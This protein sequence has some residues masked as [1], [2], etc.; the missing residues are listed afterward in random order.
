MSAEL[1]FRIGAT[2]VLI[3]ASAFF[4]ASETTFFNLLG[5]GALG[6]LDEDNPALARKLR[7]LLGAPRRLIASMLIGNEIVNIFISILIATIFARLFL[8]DEPLGEHRTLLVGL[9]SMLAST[10]LLLVFGEVI[11][12][13]IGLAF[14]R[15]LAVYMTVPFY[16]FHKIIFPIRYLFHRASQAVLRL[17]GLRIGPAQEEL[18]E[19]ELKELVELGEEEGLLDETEY[20]LLRNIFEFGDLT[21]SQ[22]MTP[23]QEV[24][25]LPVEIG[26]EEFKRK[27]LELGFSR[28]PVFRKDPDQIIGII[29][30]KDLIRIET[31]PEP[32]LLETLVRRPFCIPPQKKLN[33][34]LRD[35]LARRVNIALVVNEY[36][37]WMGLVSL[38]DLLEVIFGESGEEE[39]GAP[40]LV[41]TG[42]GQWEV[43]GG[44]SLREFNNRMNSELAAPGIKTIAG[45]LLNEFGRVPA[46]D[47]ELVRGGFRFKVKEVKGRKISRI[48]VR[49][50]DV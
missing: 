44:M 41:E 12:K 37:E 4:S 31:G 3:L 13:T 42:E 6:D 9:A 48:E 7:E 35:F 10:A 16:Y 29:T 26:F 18:K 17:L 28:V 24:K 46:A 23:K 47:E 32:R 21:A 33:D 2:L 34:L 36:G 11:P 20:V 45:Y 39:A 40:E 30:T 19:A 5:R 38:E 49:R 14:Y 25:S 22:V 8:A 43:L 27:F 1:Y 15:R 50:T